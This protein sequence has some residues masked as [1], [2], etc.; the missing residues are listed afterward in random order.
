[1]LILPPGHAQQ[2]A[3][4]RR[5]SLRERWMVGAVLSVVAGLAVVLVISLATAGHASGNGCVDVNLPFSMGGQELYR[6]GSSAKA[7]CASAGP[8]GGFTGAAE[9]AVATQCRKAGLRPGG[10]G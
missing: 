9:Q 6:C 5:F 2:V 4:G 8:A 1:M 3:A 10:Q 7:L